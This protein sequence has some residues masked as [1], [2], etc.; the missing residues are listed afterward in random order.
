MVLCG[1]NEAI[2]QLN[3][4]NSVHWHGHVLMG[5]WSCLEKGIRV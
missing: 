3:T 5:K 2:D 4:G 1:I